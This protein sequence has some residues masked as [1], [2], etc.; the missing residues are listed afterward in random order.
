MA[1]TLGSEIK[2]LSNL[3]EKNLNQSLP[4]NHLTGT[5]TAV[6]MKVADSPMPMTQKQL[7]TSLKLS[8]PTTRGIVKRLESQGYLLSVQSAADRRQME[9]HLT[10]AGQKLLDEHLDDLQKQLQKVEQQLTQAIAPADLA[11][12]KTVLHQ[13]INNF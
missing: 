1:P 7:E 4:I 3:I 13:M 2:M 9:L 11:I 12:F 5:Q 8:H 6:L 10:A